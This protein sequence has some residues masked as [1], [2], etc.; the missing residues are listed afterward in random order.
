MNK[1]SDLKPPLVIINFMIGFDILCY[2]CDLM[3]IKFHNRAAM[4]IRKIF[5]SISIALGISVVVA[6]IE[7]SQL[8]R[9]WTTRFIYMT[10]VYIYQSYLVSAV[11]NLLMY[12]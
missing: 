7:S 11:I 1:E 12:F 5:S 10:T 4:I 2:F 6:Q 8:A 9:E 3:L